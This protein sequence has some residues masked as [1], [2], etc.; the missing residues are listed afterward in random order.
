[1]DIRSKIGPRATQT[2]HRRRTPLLVGVAVAF[3]VTLVP[4][5]AY[6]APPMN[7]SA[8][9]AACE[10]RWRALDAQGQWNPEAYYKR[11]LLRSVRRTEM[12]GHF[13][14]FYTSVYAPDGREIGHLTRDRLCFVEI[15]L[16]LVELGDVLIIQD[17]YFDRQDRLQC[18]F[19][20]PGEGHDWEEPPEGLCVYRG[21]AMWEINLP[22]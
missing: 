3:A 5:L 2:F 6:S 8:S 18:R 21:G 20:P 12:G 15:H 16:R 19:R 14:A 11:V 9:S 4:A 10:I 1:M 13:Q 17:R 7:G 22:W